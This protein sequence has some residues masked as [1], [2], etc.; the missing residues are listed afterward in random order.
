MLHAL[1]LYSRGRRTRVVMVGAH[2]YFCALPKKPSPS[3]PR[4]SDDGTHLRASTGDPPRLGVLRSCRW[5]E[6]VASVLVSALST[7]S[8][9]TTSCFALVSFFARWVRCPCE[10]VWQLAGSFMSGPFDVLFVSTTICQ[11]LPS[12]HQATLWACA[13]RF[14]VRIR[15]SK[16]RA[17]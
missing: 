17:A 9:D 13:R 10:Q 15:V 7:A 2:T 6:H 3:P 5:N 4:D 16:Y 12:M 1:G 11:C 8:P 14:R